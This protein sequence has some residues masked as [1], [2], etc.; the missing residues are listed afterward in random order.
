MFVFTTLA[1]SVPV[2]DWRTGYMKMQP[3]LSEMQPV[4]IN[5]K[6]VFGN[7]V[8]YFLPEDDKNYTE[9]VFGEGNNLD[10]YLFLKL[11]NELNKLEDGEYDLNVNCLVI[12]D[13]GD[14]AYYETGGISVYN[15]PYGKQRTISDALKNTIDRKTNEVL[16][17]PLKYTPARKDGK[18]INVRVNTN[19]Y[20]VIVKNHK[21]SLVERG[22]C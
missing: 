14:I 19:N 2:K 1:D 17:A 15:S 16:D 5:G 18:A 9:P 20:E 6:P 22:G 3:V 12:D 8:K 13:R 10:T 7:E 21:A 11:Q 4:T